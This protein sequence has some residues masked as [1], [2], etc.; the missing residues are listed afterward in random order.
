M[1]MEGEAIQTQEI[2]RFVKES[3][4]DGG[5]IHGKFMATGVQPSFLKELKAYGIVVPESHFDPSREL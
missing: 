4:D 1:G 2:F 3:T 5:N